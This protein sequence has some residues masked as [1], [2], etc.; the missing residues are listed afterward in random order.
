MKYGGLEIFHLKAS[1]TASIVFLSCDKL[2]QRVMGLFVFWSRSG[3]SLFVEKQDVKR[4]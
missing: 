4:V 1:F 2:D 3:L